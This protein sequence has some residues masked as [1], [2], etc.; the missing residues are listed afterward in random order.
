MQ[1]LDPPSPCFMPDDPR[2]F[3]VIHV[4]QLGSFPSFRLLSEAHLLLTSISEP[5]RC[6][7]A[8]LVSVYLASRNHSFTQSYLTS[9]HIQFSILK[10]LRLFPL[11]RADLL[12]ILDTQKSGL[13]HVGSGNSPVN[14]ID[15]LI[16][17]WLAGGSMY[18]GL[19]QPSIFWYCPRSKSCGCWLPGCP[20]S[21]RWLHFGPAHTH[22]QP[23][24]PIMPRF[25][26]IEARR[27][28]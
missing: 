13:F 21:M 12:P 5:E 22:T 25:E 23:F 19:K 9:F 14:L 16:G 28:V 10:R 26:K 4:P 24:S 20:V 6:R 18:S 3:I 8:F 27:L 17:C 11:T 15:V 7:P 1:T 2:Y